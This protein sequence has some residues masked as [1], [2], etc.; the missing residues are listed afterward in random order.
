VATGLRLAKP[1]PD[2]DGIDFCLW[3]DDVPPLRGARST[4]INVQVKSDS[5][6]DGTIDH[7]SYRLSVPHFNALADYT[8][9]PTYLFLVIVPDDPEKHAMASPDGLVLS[10]AAYWHSFEGEDPIDGAA[11]GAKTT[12]SVPK[13]NLLT[14]NSLRTLTSVPHAPVEAS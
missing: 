11:K 9:F 10:R 8:V 7:W 1:E 4:P 2:I 3:P 12:V 14:V 6:A 5:V 13:A